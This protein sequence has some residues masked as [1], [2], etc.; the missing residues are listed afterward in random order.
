MVSIVSKA[1]WAF[2]SACLLSWSGFNASIA[3]AQEFR[4]RVQG[5]VM[6]PSQAVIVGATVTLTNVNTGVSTTRQTDQTGRYLFDLVLPG[7]YTLVFECPGFSRLVQE[8]VVVSARGDVTVNATLKPGT[9]QE[10]VT[11]SE[12]A[13]VV[14]FNT[15]K[16]EITVDRTLVDRMPQFYRNPLLLARLDPAVVQSDT[17][18]ENEP[19]FTWSGNRQEVGGGGNY[20]ND[21]Q[22]D[23][24]PIGIGYKTSYMPAPDAVEEVHVQ[25]NAVDAEY[26]HSAG[27]AIML[28]MKA[29]TNEWHGNGF[30]QG[31]YPWANALENR[32][33]RSINRGRIHMFGGTLGHPI[34]KNKLFNF[35]AYEQWKKTDPN[36][37]IMTLPTDLERTGDFSQSRNALGGVRVIYDPWTTQT[38]ADGRTI[39]RTPFPGNRIPATMIDPVARLYVDKLWKPNRP[40]T[41]PYNFQN[42]YAP[43]PI[44]YDY[45]N[46]SDRVDYVPNERWRFY[47][48]FSHLWTPVSTSNPTGSDFWLSDRGS[49]RN[50]TQVSGDVV[51]VMS[52]R[53]VLNLH[54][55]YRAFIDASRFGVQYPRDLWAKIWPNSNWYK[56]LFE[57]PTIPVLVPRMSIMGSGTGEYWFN[58]GPRGGIWDQRPNG[59]SANVKIAQQRGR[60]YLKAGFETRGT[61][62]TSL[63]LQNTF[64][65]GFQA[66]ATASTYVSP[67]LR[68]SGD[69]FATFLLGVVQPAGGNPDSWDS[70]ATSMT[71]T[72]TPQGQNR[73]FGAFINDDWKVT[74]NLTLNLGLRYEYDSAYT[75]PEDRLTRPLDLNDPIPEMQGA[76]APKMPPQLAQFYKGPTIFN[77]AFR[78][79]DS[80]NRGQWDPGIGALSPRFGVAYRLNDLT[81][82]RVGFGRFPTPWTAGTFN[83]FDTYYYGFRQVT[84]APAAV[85][86]VPQMRLSNPFPPDN[87]IIP[88]YKKSLGRYTMLGD[89]FN[90]VAE[91][92]PRSYS[93][94]VNVSLQRQLPLN[95]LLDVTFYF[96]YTTQLIGAY[97]IN[98]VD[99]RVAYEYKDAVNI[100]V[101]NPFYNYLPPEKF[102]GPLR[103][104]RNIALTTLMRKYPHYGAL[105]V[106]DGI[107]GGDM[108]YYSL[109]LRVQ[110][111]FSKGYALMAGYNYAFQQDEA[112]FNDVDNFLQKFTWQDNNRPRHRLTMAGTWEIPLGRGRRIGGGMNRALDMVI[113]G[114]DLTGFL[115]WRSGWFIRFGGLVVTGDPRLEKP[116]P[117]KWFNTAVFAPLPPYTV[118]TN[119]WQYPGLTGPG[120]LNVD[121]SLV[122]R[123]PIT[124]KY[125]TELRMDVFNVLNNMTWA[126]PVTNVYSANFGR[127]TNQLANTF[128]RRVQLGLRLE[129]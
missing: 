46:L 107:R 56:L 16:L 87:P 73:Y 18:R 90:F 1:R 67:D 111:S 89:S 68:A 28:T 47:G 115:M 127:S 40:G 8:N 2:L 62:T 5:T 13:A 57:N 14:Q 12:R 60:H 35:F 65:F 77:G 49:Q 81:S 58:M 11:V 101:P 17:A 33:I 99:P 100:S 96:N 110:R 125:R 31:Q 32:V 91:K 104:Q 6:D 21:L 34:F 27:S 24:S 94:R 129:F 114:W 71:V 7:T 76:N 124:E 72:I 30:Y 86:G 93:N 44:Y 53:T 22:I 105:N 85:L 118:R 78:F 4:G 123:I 63:L 20:S 98:Q 75:D 70:G 59:D 43:L 79:A 119:P 15:A 23:G 48:R 106:I 19:Y 95:F 97:N 45:H 42:Y 109:Q 3:L 88:T 9:V 10:T 64:G 50:A 25:Q 41:G 92:R 74:R 117:E 83:I 108:R 84:G 61:R 54:A 29:G 126:D 82:L 122:K 128:G 52:P 121:G 102:P 112:F 66:D 116:T 38:S 113:G 103:Y 26:G 51:Y 36:D 80:K 55:S 37:L 39:T 120:L 69:G